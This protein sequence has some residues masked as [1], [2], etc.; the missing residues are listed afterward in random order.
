MRTHFIHLHRIVLFHAV[1]PLAAFGGEKSGVR[2]EDD[3]SPPRHGIES[4]VL[5]RPLLKTAFRSTIGSIIRHPITTYHLGVTLSRRRGATFFENDLP[6]LRSVKLL[7][8]QPPRPGSPE[9]EVHLNKAGLPDQIRGELR[10]HL[11]GRKF[12]T[13]FEKE[14]ARARL[15]VN[16]QVYI[17]DNDDIGV[18][19]ADLFRAKAQNI[20]VRV[21]FDDLGSTMAHGKLPPSGL[22]QGFKQPAD[23]GAYL[24]GGDS[25]VLLRETLNPWLIT[26]HT[27]L[28]I[29]DR[30]VA[31]LGGMNLGRESRHEWH[32]LMV[33]VRG[34]VVEAL[35]RD[36]DQT[37]RR[38]GALGDFALFVRQK[39]MKPD[40]GPG[41][42]LRL[43]RTDVLTA[44]NEILLAMQQAIRGARTRVWIEMPYFSSDT[45]EGELKAAASRG[46]DVRLILPEKANHQIMDAGNSVIARN[47]LKAGVRVYHYPGMT[48]L[49]AMVCDGWAT[50]GSANLDT[51]SLHINRELNLS[52][53]DST[54][55]SE[56]V[57]R[58]FEPDFQK[59]I[60]LT[61]EDI[62][63]KFAPLIESITDQL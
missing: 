37:W 59:S 1:L 32:D 18:Y 29:F 46:I 9:F 61:I 38:N 45:I 60:P 21:I 35:S 62:D 17:F 30:K 42:P 43:L 15:S 10:Y 47:L 7:P 49:K 16:S 56:L 13:A 5:Q 31:F 24:V 33:S 6:S 27:K 58:V 51:I 44:R 20:P 48:H 50:V 26:D 3:A 25:N 28:H 52:F 57:T 11:G 39:D 8:E 34:P 54:L 36:F 53:S 4:T 19:C 22:P 14:L 63:L 23:I 40:E 41:A 55:V 2:T 12:F